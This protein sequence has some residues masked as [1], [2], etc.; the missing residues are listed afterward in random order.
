MS[1]SRSRITLF[2]NELESKEEQFE[3]LQETLDE[4]K[5]KKITK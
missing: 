4:L 3:I 2:K 5:Q 1:T